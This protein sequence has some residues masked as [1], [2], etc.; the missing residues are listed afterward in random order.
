M[1]F[2]TYSDTDR[3]PVRRA[4][5]RSGFQWNSSLTTSVIGFPLPS[6]SLIGGQM[7]IG[8]GL[9]T[10]CSLHELSPGSYV[11]LDSFQAVYA[12]IASIGTVEVRVTASAW[13]TRYLLE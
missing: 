6:C 10:A 12:V 1:S 13:V 8:P 5:S 11:V 7:G 3:N 2:R 9:P 4:F